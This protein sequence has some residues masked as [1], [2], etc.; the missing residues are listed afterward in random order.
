MKELSRNIIGTTT[1]KEIFEY[2]WRDIVIYAL[3]VG[4]KEDEIEY[5]YEEGLKVIPSY[6]VVP[7]WGTFGITPYRSMPRNVTYLLNL[8]RQGSLH[9]AH[10]LVLHK[11]INPMGA[12]LTIEDVVTE[13]FDWKGKSSVVRSKLTAYDQS[14][15]KVFTNIGDTL[16]GA[17]TAPGSPQFPKSEV[18]FPDRDP[19]FVEKDFIA[20]NQHL[21]Y[22][23]SG[24]TN[25]LH[26]DMGEANKQGFE[27]PIMQGLCS[28]GYACR[29]AVKHLIPHEPERMKSIEAQ[30][31][32]PLYPG[33]D[34]ELR[35]WKVDDGKAYF[36]VV[37]LATNKIV[38][39]KG[40]FEWE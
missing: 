37:N 10:K 25:R 31:R 32:S 29:L 11:P 9:M 33:R 6:G 1:G 3:G 36:R 39:E 14:G 40:I 19:D 23:M 35:L 17:Y 26:V 4:A 24:D 16:F 18:S 38:L 20:P 21:L 34:I 5:L 30:I 2:I 8:D 13:V 28:F 12:K 22:R 15:D 27:K 7:Y